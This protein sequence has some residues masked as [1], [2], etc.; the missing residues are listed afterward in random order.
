MF[1][2]TYLRVLRAIGAHIPPAGAMINAVQ[3]LSREIARVGVGAPGN[4]EGSPHT[5]GV[6]AERVQA[7]WLAS[8]WLG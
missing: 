3:L 8:K 5:L 6:V 4:R 1:I 7:R 2:I